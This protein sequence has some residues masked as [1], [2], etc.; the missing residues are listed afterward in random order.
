MNASLQPGE[1]GGPVY[2]AAGEVVGMNTAGSVSRRVGRSGGTTAGAA[3]YAIPINTALQVADLIRTGKGSDT[4]TLGYPGFLGVEVA[5]NDGTSTAGAPVSDVV[6]GT[7]AEKIGLQ[8]GDTI[9]KINGDAVTQTDA[10]G[11][12]LGDHKPGDKVSVTWID[13]SGA[14]H[15]EDATLIVGAAN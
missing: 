5:P 13:A 2:N 14:T 11:D 1:S 7:P 12:L 3:N 9:T 6:S 8:A 10:L 4:I 15:T